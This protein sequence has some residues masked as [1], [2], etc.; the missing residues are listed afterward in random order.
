MIE[1][2]A[3]NG[4]DEWGSRVLYLPIGALRAIWRL[5]PF[6]F[7]VYHVIVTSSFYQEHSIRLIIRI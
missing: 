2:V 1:P 4:A 7:F 5:F 3:T 6:F